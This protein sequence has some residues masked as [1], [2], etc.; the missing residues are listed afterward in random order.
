MPSNK[1][2]RA[3]MVDISPKEVTV[4]RAVAQ[5]AVTLSPAAFKALI[6]G[7]SPKGDVLGTARIAGIMAAKSTP[8]LIPLCHPLVLE[9][10]KVECLPQKSKH[11]VLVTAEVLCSGKTGVEMEALTAVSA[12]CLTIYDMMKWAGQDMV[13]SGIRLM[14]KSGGKSGNFDRGKT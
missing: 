7:R 11:A 1:R 2:S 12:A 9:K 5:G 4:R 13:I 10:V 14:H 8:A 6:T 3:G